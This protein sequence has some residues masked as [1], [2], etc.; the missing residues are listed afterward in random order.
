[1]GTSQA[2]EIN[3]NKLRSSP[4]FA[5]EMSAEKN[6]KQSCAVWEKAH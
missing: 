2:R 6:V 5:C 3:N 4:F 1:M